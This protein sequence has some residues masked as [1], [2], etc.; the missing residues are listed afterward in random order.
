MFCIQ[1][2]ERAKEFIESILLTPKLVAVNLT[3]LKKDNLGTTSIPVHAK[4]NWCSVRSL[5]LPHLFNGNAL[6]G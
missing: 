2:E 6:K 1:N 3:T 4:Q 5:Y